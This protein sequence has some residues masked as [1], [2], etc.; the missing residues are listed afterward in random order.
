MY[1]RCLGVRGGWRW[2][3]AGWGMGVFIDQ[4]SVCVRKCVW[5]VRHV[6][7]GIMHVCVLPY[8]TWYSTAFPT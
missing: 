1:G 3:A 5:H 6:C 2:I 4:V 7:K 8:S